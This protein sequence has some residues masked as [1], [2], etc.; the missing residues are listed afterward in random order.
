MGRLEKSIINEIKSLGLDLAYSAKKKDYKHIITGGELYY[1][2]YGEELQY[3]RNVPKWIN[4]DRVLLASDNAELLY[5][6]LYI[7][8]F[9]IS[10]D[11]LQ[12]IAE[13]KRIGSAL[14]NQYDDFGVDA[15][16]FGRHSFGVGVGIAL[17]ERIYETIISRLKPKSK[18]INFNTYII[19]NLKDLMNG[20]AEEA[21]SFAGVQELN[22]LIILCEVNENTNTLK[23]KYLMNEDLENKYESLGYNVF[24]AKNTVDNICETIESAKKSKKP[25]MIFINTVSNGDY[26]GTFNSDIMRK[27]KNDLN[28]TTEEYNVDEKTRDL[29]H[30]IVDDRIN[31]YYQKWLLEYEACRN[32]NS[33]RLNSVLDLL[34][35]GEYNIDFDESI[36]QINE[37]YNEDLMISNEKIINVIGSKNPLFFG[38]SLNNGE[39][40]KTL[41]VKSTNNNPH[42]ALGQNINLGY[43]NSILGDILNGLSLMN[44]KAFGSISAN[45][46]LDSLASIKLSGLNNIPSTYVLAD[47]SVLASSNSNRYPIEEL[48]DLQNMTN[49][50]LIRPADINEVIGAWDFVLKNSWPAVISVSGQKVKKYRNTNAKYVKYGAYMI[51]KER[52]RLDGIIIASGCDVELAMETADDLYTE[53][54]DLRVVSMPSMEL[55]LHQN[56]RYEEQLLPK[57]IKTFV[58]TSSSP[59]VWNRFV[60]KSNNIFGI[61][62]QINGGIRTEVIKELGLDKETIKRKIRENI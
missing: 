45:N 3:K 21:I 40:N 50:I 39:N 37:E 5:S 23:E 11:T 24:Y 49:L 38:L 34:E 28:H 17:G 14:S 46:L 19:C 61:N 60:D 25:S 44:L 12:S 32:L 10:L 1:S 55:F 7:S 62:T 52:M 35:H 58:I 42:D 30:K 2:L 22:K 56:P 13:H 15:E 59:L 18:L 51:R 6:T 53:G 33:T 41:L 36:F 54:I 48:N 20:S 29:Y 4:R 8:G 47:D 16:G 9:D 26:V 27:L 31:K 43:R 57:T